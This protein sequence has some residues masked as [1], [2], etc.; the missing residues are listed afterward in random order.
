MSQGKPYI[1]AR[2]GGP[3]TPPTTDAVARVNLSF[4]I[5]MQNYKTLADYID[6]AIDEEAII[7]VDKAQQKDAVERTVYTRLHNYLSSLYSYH[8]QVQAL[9]NESSNKEIENRAISPH[10]RDDSSCDY[11]S[12]LVFLLG[13]RHGF[14]HGD[15]KF[16]DFTE[17][18]EHYGFTFNTVRFLNNQ[19]KNSSVDSP[20]SYTQYL[21]RVSYDSLLPIVYIGKFQTDFGD[22]HSDVSNWLN[23]CL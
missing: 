23:G 20:D 1:P 3:S 9:I 7:V 11:V 10:H 5:V 13:L 16:L 2:T 17:K 21:S 6:G 22:F 19:F 4:S 8:E 15:Y 14:Q 18:D 12:K